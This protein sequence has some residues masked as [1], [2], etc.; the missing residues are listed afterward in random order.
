[1]FRLPGIFSKVYNQSPNIVKEFFASAYS[2]YSNRYKYGRAYGKWSGLLRESAHW[3][4]AQ[5][6]N[7]QNEQINSLI[8]LAYYQSPFYRTIID[9]RGIDPASAST[10]DVK[11]FPVINKSIVRENYAEIVT[12][13]ASNKKLTFT[14]SGTTGTSLQVPTTRESLQREYAFRWYF[15]S[16][17][18]AKFGDRI[19]FFTGH[20][21][22]PVSRQKPPFF[23]R[24]YTEN[25]IFFSIYHLSEKNMGSY[26]D[27]LNR[28]KPDYIEGYPSGI[29]VLA[30]YINAT[31]R[32]VHSPRAIFTASEMLHDF[33]RE[34]IETAFQT[35]IF[36]WYGQVEI[37][38]NLQECREHKLHV[39]E[40]YGYL[41]LLDDNGADIKPGIIGNVVATGWGNAGFPLIRYDTGDNMI[42]AL[43]QYCKCGM[44]GRI[45]ERIIG[46]D[47]D[48]I[49]TPDGRMIGR[50]DFV[51]KPIDTVKE[52]Q[53]IQNAID[54]LTIKVVPLK[55]FSVSDENKILQSLKERTG[56]G[57][58]VSI[59]IV[60]EIP[61]TKNGKFRYV[62]SNLKK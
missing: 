58:S 8:K 55:G 1:M 46:R 45:I 42:L 31:G 50:L 32:K 38:I 5:M 60:S 13:N 17:A 3:S 61:R 53:I 62:I 24:N 7:F 34:E 14:S 25:T 41:E 33:Q 35:A 10:A 19:A 11:K 4:S 40:E 51:F 52:S 56:D 44:N 2:F 15:R 6:E 26:I 22:I 43:D 9:R 59:E 21:V 54:K 36:Q 48:F 27:A 37:T 39:K 47:E 49:V 12:G 23:I 28:L 20:M 29:F 30:K 57:L 18:D 16:V